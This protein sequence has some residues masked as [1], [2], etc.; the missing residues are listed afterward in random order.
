MAL[1][2][3]LGAAATGVLQRTFMMQSSGESFFGIP[4]ILAVF[5]AVTE[6]EPEFTADV[7]QHPVEKGKEVT[8][9]IQI[10]NGTLRLKGTI[11]NS[12][13]D[14]ATSIGNLQ[15]AGID[16]I[17]SS[18]ARANLLNTGVQQ[19]AGVA[20]AS[21]LGNASNPLGGFLGGAA[22]AIARTVLLNAFQTKQI[23]DVVTKRQKYTSMAIQR[24]SF[25]RDSNTGYQLI[26]ELEFIQIRIVSPATIDL[27]QVA[28]DVTTSAVSL[29]KLGSQATSGVSDQATSAVNK[30]WLRQVVGG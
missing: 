23:V 1:D 27:T 5:D 2:L 9:H 8:D 11:S 16:L 6:E 13:I 10:K 30:S 19:A 3:L 14:L 17:T 4:Q 12:P 18:Q 24:L 20:G 7:T 25:P 15:A 21:L 22:D 26:F 28:E 29:S